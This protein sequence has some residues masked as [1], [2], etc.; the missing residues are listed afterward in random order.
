[1]PKKLEE[2][3]ERYEIQEGDTLTGLEVPFFQSPN[4]IFGQGIP[5]NQ[6]TV[7]LYLCRCGNQGKIAFPGIRTIAN[8][9]G[10][11]KDT[12]IRCI[13]GLC[14]AGWL[15]KRTRALASDSE[16]LQYLSNVYKIIT[17]LV[18]QSD[19]G[20]VAQSDQGV[21]A[22]SDHPGSTERPYKELL[23]KNNT[24]NKDIDFRNLNKHQREGFRNDPDRFVKGKYGHT[25]KR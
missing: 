10:M 15:T 17:P 20:V 22:Q 12:V 11:S 8:M 14:E 3:K 23:I 18:A 24:N 13:K 9:C 4:A 5:S 25:V 1:M 19:Q 6:I 21:V 2:L 7:Y 16:K